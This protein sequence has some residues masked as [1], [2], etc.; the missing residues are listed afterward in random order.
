MLL[1]LFIV[2]AGLEP[3][4]GWTVPLVVTSMSDGPPLLAVAVAIG[5]VVFEPMLTCACAGKAAA[6]RHNGPSAT[7]A[8]KDERMDNPQKWEFVLGPHSGR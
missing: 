2:T 6:T 1:L 5:V 3:E 4:V 8:N 7:A